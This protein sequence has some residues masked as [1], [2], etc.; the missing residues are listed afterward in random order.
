MRVRDTGVDW[1]GQTAPDPARL[2]VV[3]AAHI[4]GPGIFVGAV[5]AML[6]PVWQQNHYGECRIDAA[7][8]IGGIAID[9]GNVFYAANYH[10]GTGVH[11][12][13]ASGVYAF[14]GAAGTMR[15]TH[16]TTPSS[17]V[18]VGDGHVYL[19]ENGD[20]LVARNQ[21]AGAVAWMAT[22]SGAGSQAPVLAA[23]RVIVAASAGVI[24]FDAQ[25]G[26]PAWTAAMIAA[27]EA[28][29]TISFT[30]G[31]DG[32]VAVGG[33]VLTSMAAALGSNSLVVTARDGIHVLSLADGT[34]RWHGAIAG[35]MGS[36]HDPVPIGNVVYVTDSSGLLA[37][38]SM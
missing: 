32:L 21:S 28:P 27:T 19:V 14:D 22:V 38:R 4:D 30:G 34:D 18:S 7:D 23:G 25:T 29:S 12:P 20:T 36:L 33:P 35:S 6:Q 11:L 31:C 24:A 2:Y 17:T 10:T 37:L 13:F 15:W 26:S 1:W 3:N 16:A 8:V 5:D 9:G